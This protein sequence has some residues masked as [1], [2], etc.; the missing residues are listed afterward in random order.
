MFFRLAENDY[1]LEAIGSL[2][3]VADLLCHQLPTLIN[4]E[5]TVKLM[6]FVTPILERFTLD[7]ELSRLRH[8]AVSVNVKLESNHFVW[9]KKAVCYSLF[10]GVAI[11]GF[12]EILDVRTKRRLFRSGREAYLCG[13]T[14]VFQHLVPATFFSKRTTMAFINNNQIEEIPRQILVIACSGIFLIE[15][16]ILVRFP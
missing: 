15:I 3:V 14:K 4:D 7:I 1:F 9:G 12:A 13:W 16:T 2:H 10:E 8:V 11:D 5:F 6:L